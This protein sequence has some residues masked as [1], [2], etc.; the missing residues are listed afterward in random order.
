MI[1]ASTTVILFKVNVPVLSEQMTVVLPRVSTAGSFFINALLLAIF[2]TPSAITIVAVAGN[3]S[4]IIE[5]AKDTATKNCGPRGFPYKAP[6]K[7]IKAQ[8]INPIIVK[9]F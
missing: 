8:M 6:S 4:G 1:A 5:I 7:K 9:K 2:L 3:P